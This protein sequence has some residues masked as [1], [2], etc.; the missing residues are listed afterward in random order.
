MVCSFL[1]LVVQLLLLLLLL[2]R[3]SLPT[4]WSS[5]PSIISIIMT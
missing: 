1:Q 3:L 2:L 4:K 5:F